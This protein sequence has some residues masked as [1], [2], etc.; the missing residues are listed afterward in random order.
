MD[1][2]D[3]SPKGIVALEDVLNRHMKLS[4][5]I[6][7]LFIDNKS[8][9]MNPLLD[10]GF[11]VTVYYSANLKDQAKAGLK[12]GDTPKVKEIKIANYINQLL[13]PFAGSF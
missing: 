5:S 8:T 3:L 7:F 10:S 12:A 4:N 2:G 13:K 9:S 6:C 1:M 11:P